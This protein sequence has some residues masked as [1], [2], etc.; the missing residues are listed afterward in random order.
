MSDREF[1][2]DESDREKAEETFNKLDENPEEFDNVT[3]EFVSSD[4]EQIIH[5]LR[6]HSVQIDSEELSE[7]LDNLSKQE[8]EQFVDAIRNHFRR[9]YETIQELRKAQ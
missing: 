5:D 8:R 1:G 4:V 2:V 6:N 3:G 7:R 9:E